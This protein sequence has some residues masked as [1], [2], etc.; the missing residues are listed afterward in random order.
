MTTYMHIRIETVLATNVSPPEE[1]ALLT[2]YKMQLLHV[3]ILKYMCMF[4]NHNNLE[5]HSSSL[6]NVHKVMYAFT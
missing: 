6:L 1:L 4:S 3:Y 5:E 2:N